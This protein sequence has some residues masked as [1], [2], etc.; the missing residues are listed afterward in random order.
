MKVPISIIS[1]QVICLK[2]H[3]QILLE[4]FF[5]FCF[6]DTFYVG[7]ILP[8]PARKLPQSLE[9]IMKES[10]DEG[11]ILISFGSEISSL[12]NEVIVEMMKALAQM[13]QIAIWKFKRKFYV[14]LC[15]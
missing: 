2:G 11:V 6:A 3:I 15:K 14:S 1:Y 7:P 8:S 13:K 10:G 5:N 12:N 9:N 4:V